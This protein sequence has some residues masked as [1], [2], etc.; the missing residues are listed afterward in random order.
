MHKLENI[1]V[2]PDFLAFVWG[3]SQQSIV[4]YKKLRSMCPCAHCREKCPDLSTSPSHTIKNIS[5]VGRYGIRITWCDG[6]NAG[7][8]SLSLLY[9]VSEKQKL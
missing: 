2:L 3:N 7:I 6:H 4:N 1:N 8:Y 9:D 5:K